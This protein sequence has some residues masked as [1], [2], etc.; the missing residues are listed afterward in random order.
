M[1]LGDLKLNRVCDKLLT[2]YCP[3]VNVLQVQRSDLQPVV[4]ATQMTRTLNRM[5]A[6]FDCTAGSW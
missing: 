6:S 2:K 4:H 5:T 3:G 1:I